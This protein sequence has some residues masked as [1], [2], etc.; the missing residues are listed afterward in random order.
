MKN[1]ILAIVV[2]A[3]LC[4][5]FS[6]IA[7]TL[8]Y[9]DS[10]RSFRQQNHVLTEKL[11]T[12]NQHLSEL[13]NENN[14]SQDSLQNE[15]RFLKQ[16]LDQAAEPKS[17]HHLA[18]AIRLAELSNKSETLERIRVRAAQ[19][20]YNNDN[21]DR[22]A[23]SNVLACINPELEYLEKQVQSLTCHEDTT[24]AQQKLAAAIHADLVFHI[25]LN[26]Y[27]DKNP[28]DLTEQD[29][30]ELKRA[31]EIAN[32]LGT[33]ST[34]SIVNLFDLNLTEASIYVNSGEYPK[35]YF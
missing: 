31:S 10:N 30:I 7:G 5:P 6:F 23:F 3:G 34:F 21:Y 27:I 16:R 25:A 14:R 24:D 35:P 17:L 8:I 20:Y 11:K 9:R 15:I 19:L 26:D 28:L 18:S 22:P 13:M 32:E 33:E 12:T 4:I 2:T 1:I 29:A